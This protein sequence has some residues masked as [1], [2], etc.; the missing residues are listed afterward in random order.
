MA[1]VIFML[2]SSPIKIQC[3][4]DEKMKDI[5][6]RLNNKL[7]NNKF[8]INKVQFLYS[9]K[10]INFELTFYEQSN[11]LDKERKEMTIIIMSTDTISLNKG[12]V[13]SK[14]IICPT[15]KENCLI[16]IDNYKI[17][18]YNCK[19]NHLIDNI[20]LKDFNDL[21]TINENEIICKICNKSKDEAYNKEFNKCLD[22][23]IN[24]CPLCK[25]NHYK[26]HKI[27]DYKDIN[28]KCLN[29]KDFYISY[30]KECKIN[31]CMKC[32][33]EH[34]N[35]HTKISYMTI[36]PNEEQLKQELNI[37]KNKLDKFKE[38]VDKINDINIKNNIIEN[39]EIFYKIN[40]DL[41][42]DFNF[43]QKNYETLMNVN[44]IKDFIE[45]KDI[46]VII[47]NQNNDKYKLEKINE[48]YYKMNNKNENKNISLKISEENN[49][50]KKYLNNLDIIFIF[51]GNPKTIHAT[52]D[53]IFAEIVLKLRNLLNCKLEDLYFYHNSCELRRDC[54][55]SLLELG[56]KNFDSIIVLENDLT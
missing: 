22:C 55:K 10:L 4:L 6:N 42:Y 8:D 51:N 29:H 44:S 19:N 23:N 53:T 39:I 17:K 35:T 33:I 45:L 48:I 36:L 43:E 56:I 2:D 3:S 40:H 31:L 41:L 15:C 37:F 50:N 1:A 20:L 21:Q 12:L 27:I 28:Y 54:N 49:V 34:N 38:N 25:N 18:L 46:D 24:L 32:D 11:N 7:K 16:N 47:N 26:T 13:K 9:G 52:N 30:C 5:I 14:E